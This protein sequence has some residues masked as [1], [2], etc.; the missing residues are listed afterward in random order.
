[1]SQAT[2]L[3]LLIPAVGQLLRERSPSEKGGKTT[4]VLIAALPEVF[5]RYR[6]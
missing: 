4:F 6:R 1:M 3:S 2:D 5:V